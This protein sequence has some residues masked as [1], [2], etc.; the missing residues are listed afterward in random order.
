MNATHQLNILDKAFNYLFLQFDKQSPKSTSDKVL[1]A[2][3]SLAIGILTFGLAHASVGL[4]QGIQT[5]YRLS[6]RVKTNEDSPAPV[7]RQAEELQKLSQ[8]TLLKTPPRPPSQYEPAEESPKL[9]QETLLKTPPRPP[10]SYE[11][12]APASQGESRNVVIKEAAEEFAASVKK[13]GQDA[14]LKDLDNQLRSLKLQSSA[15]GK[16]LIKEMVKHK[17][18]EKPLFHVI[19]KFYP[20]L[21]RQDRGE[22]VDFLLAEKAAKAG[23]PDEPFLNIRN[24][25]EVIYRSLN[26]PQPK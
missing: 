23:Q 12:V 14:F 7:Q 22:L 8:E 9:S 25:K 4:L 24:F 20:E 19:N 11:T 17:E 18:L 2:V 10:S 21:S 26:V 3:S 1:N 6:G 13:S 15:E 5:A 16:L